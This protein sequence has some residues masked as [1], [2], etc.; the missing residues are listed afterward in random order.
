MSEFYAD[1]ELLI[2]GGSVR[3]PCDKQAL[4]SGLSAQISP[5]GLLAGMGWDSVQSLDVYS[6]V[7]RSA[8]CMN[9]P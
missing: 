2:S 8:K 5:Q 1:S 9:E 3:T 6:E 7:L 4:E